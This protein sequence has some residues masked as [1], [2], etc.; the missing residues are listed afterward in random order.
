MSEVK[1]GFS[2]NNC[3]KYSN[4]RVSGHLRLAGSEFNTYLHLGSHILTILSGA[5]VTRRTC[6][7]L[8]ALNAK[9]P[10]SILGFG[11]MV[12]FFVLSFLIKRISYITNKLYG[13]MSFLL[14]NSLFGPKSIS[15]W[16][17]HKRSQYLWQPL[18]LFIHEHQT[19]AIISQITTCPLIDQVF[20]EPG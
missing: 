9:I 19:H 7:P 17:F 3:V 2:F 20:N 13:I 15:T 11:N 10:S 8:L 1:N 6:I 14:L 5:V 16:K 12:D 18:V 4:K